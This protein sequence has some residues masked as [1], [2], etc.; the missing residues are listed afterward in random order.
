MA[1]CPLVLIFKI[2]QYAPH[3]LR[4]GR[5]TWLCGISQYTLQVWHSLAHGLAHG[6]VWPFLGH[7]GVCVSRVTQ[8]NKLTCF[9]T[10]PMT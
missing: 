2:S 8:V 1:V 3:G 5:V 6:H 10:G 4:H 7:T 9:D